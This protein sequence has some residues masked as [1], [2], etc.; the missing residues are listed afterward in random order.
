[1]GQWMMLVLSRRYSTLPALDSLNSLGDVGS[2]GTGL[3]GRH[4]ALRTEHLT[5]TADNTHHVRGSD[6]DVEVEPVFLLDLLDEVHL[7]DIVS[8]GSLGSLSLVALGEDENAD[9]LAGA[10]GAGRWRRGP[11]GQRDGSRRPA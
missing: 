3:R 6:D 4:Q 5:E 8:A 10:V 7:A 9:V 2:D 11:A 1:M